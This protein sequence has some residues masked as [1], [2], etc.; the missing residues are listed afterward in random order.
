MKGAVARLINV[1]YYVH[2][3]YKKRGLR[4][5]GIPL[6]FCEGW[7]YIS[8]VSISFP[9]HPHLL[10]YYRSNQNNNLQVFFVP[11]PNQQRTFTKLP[12]E[13]RCRNF[14]PK[15]RLSK[16]IGARCAKTCVQCE[17][18][19]TELPFLHTTVGGWVPSLSGGGKHTAAHPLIDSYS[20]LISCDTIPNFVEKEG[21]NLRILARL[22]PNKPSS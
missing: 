13:L 4:L 11:L 22:I 20:N 14:V 1:S 8:D 10:C 17:Y 18:I 21:D 19:P 12:I 9:A 5:V 2:V 3:R 16:Q 6:F 7:T 15:H